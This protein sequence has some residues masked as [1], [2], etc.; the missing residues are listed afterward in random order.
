MKE[1]NV[2]N[3]NDTAPLNTL[4]GQLAF[5]SHLIFESGL[6]G[7]WRL[8]H[9]ETTG[10]SIHIVT[11]GACW[12]AFPGS[13]DEQLGLEIGDII[14]FTATRR[15]WLAAEPIKSEHVG[16]A[17]GADYCE[18]S[19]VSGGL[20][21]YDIQVESALTKT[22][23]SSLPEVIHI[24]RAAQSGDLNQLIQ[25][26]MSETKN[27]RVGSDVA[28]SRLSD[29]LVLYF[30]RQALQEGLSRSGLLAAMCDDKLKTIVLAIMENPEFPWTVEALANRS[31]LSKSAFADRCRQITGL[32]PKHLVG[33]LRLHK[34]RELLLQTELPLE[35]VAEKI[36]YQSATAFIRFFKQFTGLSPG[37]FRENHEIR[38]FS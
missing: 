12:L 17:M 18:P 36:G 23:F 10:P 21:C 31:F 4:L 32:A 34:A 33:E 7:S 5:Q 35:V 38:H 27:Q 13:L 29:V 28:I 1:D 11:S 30:L 15:H 25:L 24:P 6:C 2:S 19:H 8:I 14:L 26:I 16:K 20:V 3:S 37:D 22:I 9:E